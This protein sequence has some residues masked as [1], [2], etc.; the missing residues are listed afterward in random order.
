MLF[1]RRLQSFLPSSTRVE[2]CLPVRYCR[3]QYLRIHPTASEYRCAQSTEYATVS[4]TLRPGAAVLVLVLL[5][6]IRTETTL[7]SCTPVSLWLFVCLS[8]LSPRMALKCGLEEATRPTLYRAADGKAM[9]YFLRLTPHR[10]R[11]RHEQSEISTSICCCRE[12]SQGLYL[13][14][15]DRCLHTLSLIHI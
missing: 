1:A 12:T 9:G 2:L 6:P 13:R 8:L 7:D 14:V 5:L 4:S 11:P 15:I 3:Y 10:S